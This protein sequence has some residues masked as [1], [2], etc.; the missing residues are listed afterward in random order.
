MSSRDP[1]CRLRAPRAP[2]ALRARVLAAVAARASERENLLD[3]LWRSRTWWTFWGATVTLLAMA[4]PSTPQTA[5]LEQLLVQQEK[6][7]EQVRL[8]LEQSGE[9]GSPRWTAGPPTGP[10]GSA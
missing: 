9:V 6:R 2:A 4:L 10:A 7:V 5:S 3:R 1:L 8:A